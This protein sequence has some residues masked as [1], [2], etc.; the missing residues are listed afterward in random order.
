MASTNSWEEKWEIVH[1]NLGEG[2]QGTT[3]LVRSK[4]TGDKAVLKELKDASAPQARRRMRFEVDALKML[5]GLGAIVPAVLDTNVEH[6]DEVSIPLYFVMEFLDGETLHDY[7]RTRSKLSVEESVDFVGQIAATLEIGHEQGFGHRDIKPKNLMIVLDA[8]D[9]KRVVVLDYGISFN[10]D[11]EALT[12]MSENFWNEFYTL[13]ETN[14]EGGRRRD[15]RTDVAMLCA[16]LFFC[17]TGEYPQG[18]RDEEERPPHRRPGKSLKEHIDDPALIPLLDSMLFK[19]FSPDI[20]KRFQTIGEFKEELERVRCYE[21]SPRAEDPKLVAVRE[22]ELIR[23]HDRRTQL[24][25][26][27]PAAESA[28]QGLHLAI[29]N[30]SKELGNFAVTLQGISPDKFELGRG[31]EPAGLLALQCQLTIRPHGLQKVV[32]YMIA[33]QDFDFVVIRFEGPL[34]NKKHTNG[35]V[36]YNFPV[37]ED[38]HWGAVEEEHKRWLNKSFVE[39]R[40][41]VI[42]KSVTTLRNIPASVDDVLGA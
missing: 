6:A 17:L 7:V 26:M 2:G 32:W 4:T 18:P 15:L 10:A 13:P 19:G 31:I 30:Y 35:K 1:R 42:R 3:H 33:V 11:G 16:I 27:K 39:L 38:P 37:S 20:N 25:E 41:Q 8:H 40:E 24:V 22:T 5:S 28:F 29:S 12:R 23:S 36:L 9:A 14:V 34:V 21:K